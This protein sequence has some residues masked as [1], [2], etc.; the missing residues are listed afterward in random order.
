M[1]TNRLDL[2]KIDNIINHTNTLSGGM[3]PRLPRG[4]P[5]KVPP[6]FPIKLPPLKPSSLEIAMAEAYSSGSDE[7]FTMSSSSDEDGTPMLAQDLTLERAFGDVIAQNQ[8][9]S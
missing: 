1:A 7:D 8:K 2:M 5:P 9:R 6:R 3:L 4:P